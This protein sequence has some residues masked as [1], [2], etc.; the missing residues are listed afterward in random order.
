MRLF[1]L[2]LPPD[3]S[4]C[5]TA[6]VDYANGYFCLQGFKPGSFVAN[7]G[8]Y[9]G[10]YPVVYSESRHPAIDR[11]RNQEG[12]QRNQRIGSHGGTARNPCD[13]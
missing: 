2:V 12:F 10:I 1:P 9:G 6:V 3:E 7:L 5:R 13:Q 4:A 8:G 11:C